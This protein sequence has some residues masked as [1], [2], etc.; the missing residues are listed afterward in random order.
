[1]MSSRWLVGTRVIL[2]VEAGRSSSGPL[3]VQHNLPYYIT[4]QKVRYCT[5][6]NLSINA[7]LLV[8]PS[9]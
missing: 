9:R 3:T 1:M 7:V 2:I 8:G 5:N 6:D 4:P